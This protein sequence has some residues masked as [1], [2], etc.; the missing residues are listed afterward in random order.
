MSSPRSSRSSVVRRPR[1]DPALVSEA[2]L[3]EVIRTSFA[4]RRKMLRRSLAGWASDGVFERA[5]VQATRRPEELTLEEFA[6][7]AAEQVIE[8]LAPAKLTWSL[9]ITGVREDGLHELRSEMTT[10]DLFDRLVGRRRRGLPATR[11]WARGAGR[12]DQSGVARVVDCSIVA[13]AS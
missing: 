13:R 11:A 2:A 7:L 12:R 8:L 9:E 6:R 4:Q 5:D 10:L 3:F 1:I